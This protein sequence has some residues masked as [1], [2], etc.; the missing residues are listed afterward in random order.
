M[1][2]ISYKKKL[3]CLLQKVDRSQSVRQKLGEKLDHNKIKE[4]GAEEV[5]DTVGEHLYLYI[6]EIMQ[7]FIIFPLSCKYTVALSRCYYF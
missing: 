1:R 6:E 5:R 3:Q 2:F 4:M 7:H